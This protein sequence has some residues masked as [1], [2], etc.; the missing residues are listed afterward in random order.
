MY[1][2]SPAVYSP[3]SKKNKYKSLNNDDVDNDGNNNNNNKNN[4][5]HHQIIIAHKWTDYPR[6]K[7]PVSTKSKLWWKLGSLIR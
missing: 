1:T 7:E 3:V 2:P 5:I 4:N 6:E